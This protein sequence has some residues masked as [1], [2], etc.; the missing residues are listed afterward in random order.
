[1]I[2]PNINLAEGQASFYQ[3]QSSIHIYGVQNRKLIKNLGPNFSDLSVKQVNQ[4]VDVKEYLY[5]Q[6]RLSYGGVS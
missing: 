3:G 5:I 6:T 2:I 1:M 4:P